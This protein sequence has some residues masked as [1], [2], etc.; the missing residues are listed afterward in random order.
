MYIYKKKAFTMAEVLITLGII[1]VVAALTMPA[2]IAKYRE[3]ALRTQFKKAY[4]AFSQALQ[5][6]ALIDYDGGDAGCQYYDDYTWQV[7]NCA[8]FY[9]KFTQNMKVI[10]TC[11][12]NV[13]ECIPEYSYELIGNTC[14]GYSPAN[15]Q[16]ATVYVLQDGMIMIPYGGGYSDPRF[17]VDTNGKKGPNKPGWDLFDFEFI[18]S[19]GSYRL[20]GRAGSNTVTYCFAAS[21]DML[22]ETFDD[23]Y[24]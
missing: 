9:Q 8:E 3:Q 15:V 23:I 12:G 22:F 19:N 2:L 11:K 6:T 14:S 10:K 21:N 17:L 1:G 20:D 24:K 7:S 4:S 18:Y 5:K 16:N 13:N